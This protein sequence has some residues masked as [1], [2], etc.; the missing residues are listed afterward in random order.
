MLENK[1][2]KELFQFYAKQHLPEGLEF[3]NI[4]DK[5]K[6]IDMGEF[7]IF[8]RDFEIKLNKK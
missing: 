2:L 8:C 3:G 7:C 1:G 5:M 6:V 4:L